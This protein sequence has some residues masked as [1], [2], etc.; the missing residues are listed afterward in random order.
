[1]LFF[2]GHDD[3]RSAA[4]ATPTPDLASLALVFA[5]ATSTSSPL[6]RLLKSSN[7]VNRIE[8]LT[9]ARAE[10]VTYSRPRTTL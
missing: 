4:F 10:A 9:A 8:S 6:I 7:Q 1:L 3:T 2:F 5:A